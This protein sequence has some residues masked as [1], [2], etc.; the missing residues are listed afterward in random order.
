L[1]AGEWT[2]A[3]TTDQ[4][5]RD[6]LPDAQSYFESQ[7]LTL[8]K[9]G[10]WRTTECVFHG[11]S[12]SMRIN[13]ERGCWVCMACPARGGDVLAY[14][15]AVHYMSFIDAAKDLGAW[16][17]DGSPDRHIRPRPLP[18][19]EAIRVLKTEADIAAYVALQV[20]NG[21]SLRPADRA[22]LMTAH[23]RICHISELFQ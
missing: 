16:V 17:D 1:Q 14:H 3:V 18:A 20:A 22:R 23:Q 13:L 9:R 4:F 5:Q 8:S 10:K 12:D 6:R 21:V 2:Q 7:R 15:M 11:G 19:I